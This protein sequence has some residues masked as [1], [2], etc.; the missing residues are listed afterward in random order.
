MTALKAPR[1]QVVIYAAKMR[2]KYSDTGARANHLMAMKAEYLVKRYLGVEEVFDVRFGG[3]THLFGIDGTE[4]IEPLNY[5]VPDGG[6][7]EVK[8]GVSVR[9]DEI[10]GYLPSLPVVSVPEIMTYAE[11]DTWR[12]EA[13]WLTAGEIA[14][15]G[16]WQKD[17]Q[18]RGHRFSYTRHML[19]RGL[20]VLTTRT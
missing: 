18:G 4:R 3:V 14:D 12:G 9:E 16:Q 11:D 5:R 19:W 20:E 2:N 1:S 6:W 7:F 15:L 17:R 10:R 13:G 8:S